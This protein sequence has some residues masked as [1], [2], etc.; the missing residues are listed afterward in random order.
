M[1]I[2]SRRTTHEEEINCQDNKR[3]EE[4]TIE[5]YKERTNIRI[6]EKERNGNLIRLKN[7]KVNK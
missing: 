7:T 4:R 2:T 3:K 6:Q 1:F 5:S